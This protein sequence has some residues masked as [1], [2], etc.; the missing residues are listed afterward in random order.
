MSEDAAT[1]QAPTVEDVVAHLETN[2]V[3]LPVDLAQLALRVR[4]YYRKPGNGAGGNLHIV[5]DDRNV[6]AS[7]LVFCHNRCEAAGDEDGVALAL[8]LLDLS[9]IERDWF[10]L[11]LYQ[12]YAL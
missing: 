2:G 11:M 4:A 8:D 3:T 9:R 6:E 10:T 1:V 7:H 5:L 12:F